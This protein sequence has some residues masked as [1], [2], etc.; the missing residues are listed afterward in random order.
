MIHFFYGLGRLVP[1]GRPILSAIA[2][3]F[4]ECLRGAATRP[5]LPAHP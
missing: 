4:G 5:I 2:R 1:R 3:D